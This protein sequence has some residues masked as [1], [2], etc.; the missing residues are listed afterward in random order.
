MKRSSSLAVTTGC[1]ATSDTI[2]RAQAVAARCDAAYAP[3][4]GSLKRTCVRANVD[5]LYVVEKHRESLRVPTGERIGVDQG[6]LATRRHEGA[7]HPL[8]RATAIEGL[9]CIMDGTLGLG[10]DALHMAALA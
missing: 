3:R 8:I 9:Q 1:N 10:H 4:N 5:L 2:A 7:K 6:M